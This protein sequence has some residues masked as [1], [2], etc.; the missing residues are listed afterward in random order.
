M[1]VQACAAMPNLLM[2]L[3]AALCLRK[4]VG[5]SCVPFPGCDRIM[6]DRHQLRIKP[7]GISP[8]STTTCF[9]RDCLY[10]TLAAHE[11]SSHIAACQLA[12]RCCRVAGGSYLYEWETVILPLLEGAASARAAAAE[13]AAPEQAPADADVLVCP[14]YRSCSRLTEASLSCLW[15]TFTVINPCV[16]MLQGQ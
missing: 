10:S 11:D 4:G 7:L 9:L 14:R 15:M 8:Q 6:H 16:P 12:V 13:G 3:R 1:I 2:P 5:S